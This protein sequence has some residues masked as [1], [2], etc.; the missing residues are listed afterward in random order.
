[1][2]R[3]GGPGH[4]GDQARQQ[5]VSSQGAGAPAGERPAGAGTNGDWRGASD[6]STG[7]AWTPGTPPGNGPPT[8]ATRSRPGGTRPRAG[9]RAAGFHKPR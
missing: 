8:S 6:S 5:T 7:A 3:P 2:S 4:P 9:L 1:M